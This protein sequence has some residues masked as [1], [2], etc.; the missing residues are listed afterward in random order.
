MQ[1][2]SLQHTHP[3]AIGA[4]INALDVAKEKRKNSSCSHQ[5]ASTKL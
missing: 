3:V 5:M 2:L 1:S 4:W